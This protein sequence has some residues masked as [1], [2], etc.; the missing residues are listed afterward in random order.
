M[1]EA[2]LHVKDL[3]WGE[4]N[5]MNVVF[6]CFMIAIIIPVILLFPILSMYIVPLKLEGA[7]LPLY[8]VAV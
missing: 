5:N 6:L 7:K 2:A 1:C 8:K 4:T 3:F